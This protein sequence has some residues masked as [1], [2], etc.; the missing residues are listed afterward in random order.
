MSKEY[1][2]VIG[3]TVKASNFE[4]RYLG[5]IVGFER[6]GKLI[7]DFNSGDTPFI[8]IVKDTKPLNLSGFKA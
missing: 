6:D 5:V 4:G 8:R 1:N 3:D 2:F 7:E